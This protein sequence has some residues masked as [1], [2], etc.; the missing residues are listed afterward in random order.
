MLGSSSRD[1]VQVSR[2]DMQGFRSA[3]AAVAQTNLQIKEH[4]RFSRAWLRETLPNGQNVAMGNGLLSPSAEDGGNSRADVSGRRW[5]GNREWLRHGAAG[6][7]LTWYLRL[8]MESEVGLGWIAIGASSS[9]HLWG[10]VKADK[11][12][13]S[14]NYQIGS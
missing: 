7:L 2:A 8:S 3:F 13:T 10:M 6:T 1:F 11:F 4:A 14:R 5:R 12:I 9:P